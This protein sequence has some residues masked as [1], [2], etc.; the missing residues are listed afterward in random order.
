LIVY[1]AGFSGVVVIFS[2]MGAL[3]DGRY[4]AWRRAQDSRRWML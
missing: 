1:L 4:V 3:G 2:A